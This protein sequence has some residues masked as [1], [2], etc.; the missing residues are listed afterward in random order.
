MTTEQETPRL[1]KDEAKDL[2]SKIEGFSQQLSPTQRRYLAYALAQ[3]RPEGEVQGYG[4]EIDVDTGYYD[5]NTGL[6]IYHVYYEDNAGNVYDE[7]Y[8]E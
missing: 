6:E 5:V 4:W 1:N 7:G 8:W 3:A 2:H